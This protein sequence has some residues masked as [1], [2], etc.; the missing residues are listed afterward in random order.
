MV[1]KEIKR[2]GNICTKTQPEL[3]NYLYSVLKSNGYNPVSEDGFLYAKGELPY[4]V[5]AHMDTVH[6][7]QVSRYSVHRFKG[8]HR[9]QSK[10]GIGGDDRCGVWMIVRMVLDGYRPSILFCEDEEI[11]SVGA[12]K[13]CKTKYLDDLC[14]MRYLIEL[15]RAHEKDAVFYDC[16]NKD[17]TKFIL[18]T[19]EYH[20]EMGSFSDIV[21]LS[22]NS[23][24]ASVNLSCGYYNAHKTSEYVMF[25]EMQNT[26]K[27]VE[28]LLRTE[29]QQ[30][31]YVPKARYGFFKNYYDDDWYLYY[32]SKMKPST[33]KSAATYGGLEIVYNTYT[34]EKDGTYTPED[35]CEYVNGDTL[36]ECFEIFF[37]THPDIC[38]GDVIDYYEI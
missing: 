20:E 22:E 24:I 38:Y 15:D 6:K 34:K 25:E 32:D 23:G 14:D 30:F 21:E 35:M 36:E 16:D 2:F 17:F 19:T 37:I 31:E 28:K 9:I 29:C 18:E 3:K 27:V 12:G 1:A 5:T 26:L 4:L 7:V 10:V 8:M 13:F 33:K 11:G